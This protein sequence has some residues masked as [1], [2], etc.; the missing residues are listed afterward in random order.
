MFGYIKINKSEL[1]I[2]DYNIYKG[3]YCTLCKEMG[4]NFGLMSRFTLNYDF[5]FLALIK[6]SVVNDDVEFK[7]SRCT[8]NPT[9]K[10][11]KC[12]KQ[13]EHILFSV[14]ISMIILYYKLVDNIRDNKF[15]K[16]I[17]TCLLY[18]IVRIYHKKAIKRHFELDEIIK[19]EI[20][21]QNKVE[22]EKCK[23][24][25]IASNPTSVMLGKIFSAGE[26]EENQKRVLQHLGFCIG[27][28]IYILDAVEDFSKDYKS[29]SYNTFV[30]RYI[31][32]N[33]EDLDDFKFKVTS[34]LNRTLS[35]IINTYELLQVKSNK[36]ILD[37]II[38]EGLEL[39]KQRVIGKEVSI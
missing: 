33:Y 39:E 23:N 22:K 38:F 37:N 35:E 34:I 30:L 32:N 13:N 17:L 8:F 29:G 2:R 19:N 24:I 9:H 20:E 25:D 16:K 18:P 4:K 27:R 11:L 26:Y 3:I 5:A 36:E 6:M 14:Y 15:I 1:K 7:K 12:T 21:R 28:Y 10:C 31:D